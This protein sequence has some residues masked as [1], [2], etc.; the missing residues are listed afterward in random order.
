[1]VFVKCSHIA[2][3]K[4]KKKKD[5]GPNYIILAIIPIMYFSNQNISLSI[6]NELRD[7]QSKPSIHWTV[8]KIKN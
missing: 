6:F 1:M 7:H 4:K 2:S 8:L 3:K 5:L